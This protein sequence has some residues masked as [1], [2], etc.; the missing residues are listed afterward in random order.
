MATWLPRFVLL[1]AV[2]C[3]VA[4]V[5][6][7]ISSTA[8]HVGSAVFGIF[9]VPVAGNVFTAAL[10]F[11]VGSALAVRKR[12]ALWFVLV[13]FQVGWLVVAAFVTVLRAWDVR[14]L[15]DVHVDNRAE[16]VVF[17][18]SV[19][20]AFVMIVVL[21]RIRP[22]FP[23]RLAPGSWKRALIALVA[24]VGISAGVGILLTEA[25]PNSLA[26]QRRKVLWPIRTAIGLEPDTDSSF[27]RG[28]GTPWVA[29]VIGALSTV[30]LL[31]AFAVLLRAARAGRH[32][33]SDDELALRRL[34]R[35]HGEADSLG[36]FATRRDKMVLFAPDGRGRRHV[37]RR[38]RH[39]PGQRRPDRRSPLVA[40]GHRRLDVRG[41]RVRLGARG[42]RGQRARRAGVPAGRDADRQPRRRGRARRQRVPPQRG[43]HGAG[44]PG[45][46]A[47]APDG[48]IG[49]WCAATA[50]SR[51]TRWRCSRSW[52]SAGGATS[53]SAAS[54]CRSGASATPPTCA[55]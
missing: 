14:A 51:P 19:A 8:A 17:I 7:P 41:A 4:M 22:L 48:L 11:V 42:D 35:D 44:A 18:L 47:R 26:G 43:R 21:W 20:M 29:G 33:E 16:D 39:Q 24:G 50:R 38:G 30:A 12:A 36:Y 23:A 27:Y 10:L 46:V 3:L 45:G 1:A 6:T 13:A 9:N 49:W 54:R 53:P 34:L 25:F 15:P 32:L 5:L 37:P 31:W 55:A 40:G 52:P 28:T 2:W